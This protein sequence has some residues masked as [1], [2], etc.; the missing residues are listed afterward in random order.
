MTHPIVAV[1]PPTC[2]PRSRRSP[3][4]T[5]PSCRPTTRP[6]RSREPVRA[7]AQL[8]ELRLRIL[9]DAGDLAAST[10]ARDAAGWLAQHHPHPL[11]RRARR[12]RA[13]LR[14]RPRPSPARH[15][16]AGGRGN[17]LAGP[18]HPPLDRRAAR[19]PWTGTPSPVPRSTSSHRH[20]A[21]GPRELGRI[22]RRILDVVAPEIAEAAE[23]ARLADL[24]ANADEQHPAHPPTPRGRHH[25]HLGPPPRRLRTHA[26]RPSWSPTPTRASLPA[27]PLAAGDPLP[28]PPPPAT[29]GPGVR[30]A[31][32]GARPGPTADPRRRRDD[33]CRHDPARGTP[34]RACHRRRH[35][36][37]SGA[38]R[39]AHG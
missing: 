6:W 24:E 23:A 8:D 18:R 1:V 20:R 9:G 33:G 4:P 37:R 17:T 19:E 7:S 28:P 16:D 14:T 15:G 30:P 12:P 36:R 2:V 10:A 35:R 26:S 3:T 5:R 25:P 32:R 34:G 38:R 29:S 39:R 27:P 13:R 21:F 31:P 11:R 22:G